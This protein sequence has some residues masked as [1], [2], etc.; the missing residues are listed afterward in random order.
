MNSPTQNH[1]R[2]EENPMKAPENTRRAADP[3]MN[4]AGTDSEL[5][6]EYFIPPERFSTEYHPE[7]EIEYDPQPSPVRNVQ[8]AGPVQNV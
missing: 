8:N 2:E 5:P 7:F 6:Y 1:N 3:E 4:A